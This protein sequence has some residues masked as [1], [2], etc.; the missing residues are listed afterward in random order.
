[1]KLHTA[2]S[3][4]LI[5]FSGYSLA[6]QLPLEET[7]D[8]AAPQ[9]RK[10]P[11]NNPQAGSILS[12]PLYLPLVDDAAWSSIMAQAQLTVIPTQTY[13]V[14]AIQVTT[15]NSSNGTCSGGSGSC[16]IGDTGGVI[17]LTAS[18][19]YRTTDASNQ[20]IYNS[21]NPFYTS[22]DNTYQLLDS[23]LNPIGSPVCVPGSG[24][25]CNSFTNCG[26]PSPQTWTP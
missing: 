11:V 13:A 8:N 2:L 9:A 19:A 20:A 18:H 7:S 15:W 10:M 12:V 22:L 24:G 23:S 17:S 25:V 1:M 3:I 5:G 6:N 21:C 14:R 16:N 26:W 4:F